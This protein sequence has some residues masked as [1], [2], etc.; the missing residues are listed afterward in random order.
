MFTLLMAFLSSALSISVKV[1][2]EVTSTCVGGSVYSTT[3]G[4]VPV[5]D[6]SQ[7][8]IPLVGSFPITDGPYNEHSGKEAIDFSAPAGTPVVAARGGVLHWK[9]DYDPTRDGYGDYIEI[10]HSDGERSIYAHLSNRT[11]GLDGTTVTAGTLIGHSGNSGLKGSG[12]YHLHFEVKKSVDSYV[13]IRRLTGSHFFTVEQQGSDIDCNIRMPDG[14]NDG[15]AYGESTAQVSLPT[16]KTAFRCELVNQGVIVYRADECQGEGHNLIY[17]QNVFNAKEMGF[18]VHSL[19]IPNGWSVF[20]DDGNLQEK[21]H[22]CAT[23]S[24]WDL[25][26]DYYH[27][28]EN[29]LIAGNVKRVIAFKDPKCGKRNVDEHGQLLDLSQYPEYTSPGGGGAS[30]LIPPTT[31]GFNTS[32]SGGTASLS[33]VGASDTGGSGIKEVS[34]SA[35]W[36]GKWYFAGK[37]TQGSSYSV[38]FNLCNAGV[39]NGDVEFGMEI[40]DNA[41]N[42]WIWSQHYTN[43]H[44]TKSYN[45]SSG[46]GTPTPTPQS[47]TNIGQFDKTWAYF[48]AGSNCTGDI[49][50]FSQW[51]SNGPGKSWQKSVY[52]PDGK[53]LK[54]SS[55]NDGGGDKGCLATSVQNLADIGWENRIE[56][57]QLVYGPCPTPVPVTPTPN[58][59]P[60]VCGSP[61]YAA[62]VT[63]TIDQKFLVDTE[64]QLMAVRF[65]W[66][67]ASETT[68]YH[69]QLSLD[70]AFGSF[71]YDYHTS[72]TE[73]TENLPVGRYYWR[74]NGE[75]VNTVCQNYGAWSN[76]W[77]FDILD[78]SNPET[79]CLINLPTDGVRVFSEPYC[80]GES[81]DLP[82]K[83]FG[84]Y[85]FGGT[86]WNDEISS[87]SMALG[88]RVRLYD[89]DGTDRNGGQ[90]CFE[91][92]ES[93][94]T[95]LQYH[96]VPEMTVN[97]S[98]S[99][100]SVYQVERSMTCAEMMK[101]E[102][103]RGSCSEVAVDAGVR[104][105]KDESCGGAY[106]N[107]SEG[108]Y[109]F[110]GTEWDDAVDSIYVTEGMSVLLY[111]N[112]DDTGGMYCLNSTSWDMSLNYS[113][114]YAYLKGTVSRID[115]FNNDSC[116]RWIFKYQ[117]PTCSGV[118]A[119]NGVLLY[120]DTNCGGEE[121]V[122][123]SF[124]DLTGSFFDDSISSIVID[125]GHSALIGEKT[126]Y[127]EGMSCINQT[128]SDLESQGYQTTGSGI[129]D[130]ISF[131]EFFDDSDC[132]GME[133]K[134]KL[135]IPIITSPSSQSFNY[136]DKINLYWTPVAYNEYYEVWLLSQTGEE[137]HWATNEPSF[138]SDPSYIYLHPGH[139]SWRIRAT[140][141]DGTNGDWSLPA[142]FDLIYNG[143]IVNPTN[144]ST[145]SDHFLFGDEINLAWD[146]MKETSNYYVE[147][148]N[149]SSNTS[150]YMY[151]S[152]IGNVGFGFTNLVIGSTYPTVGEYKW[153]VKSIIGDR[154]SEWSE[155]AYFHVM[156]GNAPKAPSEFRQIGSSATSIAFSWK[157]N[158]SDELGFVIS[159]QSVNG[160]WKDVVSLLAETTSYTLTGLSC[161]YS[162]TYRVLAYNAEG[163]SYSNSIVA[164]TK[165][166]DAQSKTYLPLIAK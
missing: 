59:T 99:S 48:W 143:Q 113:Y 3:K 120:T 158:S 109:A 84:F 21:N 150:T 125:P 96:T 97:D 17:D 73:T 147:L 36:G 122:S 98:I 11:T 60:I 77:Q 74:V 45:C 135:G 55:D 101:D 127:T 124:S 123:S 75:Y 140:R 155:Y 91:S 93:D 52:V 117:E 132:N 23:R 33:V 32:I 49:S 111:E 87:I 4:V 38:S 133:L 51:D 6:I 22:L 64:G 41:G 163:D 8:R 24:L 65:D 66:N 164:T 44:S 162:A 161:G 2:A 165:A 12:R 28:L 114:R 128:I 26:M 144:L 104:V 146:G 19:Y 151:V 115:I 54:I 56:W 139:F 14:H 9:S 118:V 42:Y 71:I 20:I 81:Q 153:R 67:E 88:Y 160:E 1:K 83:E 116:D 92:S 85:P 157:G 102:V 78:S 16:V 58:A 7:Y 100:L 119:G 89:N 34:Y 129:G 40:W 29:R 148:L 57:A 15:Y 107:L 159:V 121:L 106:E 46:G 76:T 137:Q 90:Q 31:T 25:N 82:Y 136:G 149:T 86:A 166:C 105:Y 10:Q 37:S 130:T 39:P 131:V 61:A 69:F 103:A 72:S 50:W 95:K 43:P 62:Q 68:G 141:L 13:N 79:N 35:K 134:L 5:S 53:V 156:S 47:C 63:P 152:P 18:D 112:V 110:G 94:L 145:P 138:L 80:Q 30:D 70:P 126:D 154:E 108:Q 142:E 27:P